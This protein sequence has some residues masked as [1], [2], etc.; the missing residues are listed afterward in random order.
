MHVR[1]H[2][3][4]PPGVL[5]VAVPLAVPPPFLLCRNKRLRS[6]D[7]AHAACNTLRCVSSPQPGCFAR[8]ATHLHAHIHLLN[9]SGCHSVAAPL[10]SSPRSMLRVASAAARAAAA[11]C[12]LSQR[13]AWVQLSSQ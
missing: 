3:L 10:S 4:H 5:V 12:S 9:L 7:G 8:C 13:C 2:E 1:A 11:P 6:F